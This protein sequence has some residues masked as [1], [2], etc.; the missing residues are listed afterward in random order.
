LAE[1]IVHLPARRDKSRPG[2]AVEPKGKKP[3]CFCPGANPNRVAQPL[4]AK[5]A[6]D[7]N[8][9]RMVGQASAQNGH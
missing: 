9:R 3:E 2:V 4:I 6:K 7:G 1:L 5:M 8:D